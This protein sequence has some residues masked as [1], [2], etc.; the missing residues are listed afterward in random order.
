MEDRRTDV[1]EV[2]QYKK[3]VLAQSECLIRRPLN[4]LKVPH[5]WTFDKTLYPQLLS[6]K[7]KI[8]VSH[9]GLEQLPNTINANFIR[10]RHIQAFDKNKT[11]DF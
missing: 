2:H 3:H 9:F 6:V 10:P 11:A 7:Y 4:V 5:C 8:N 1:D